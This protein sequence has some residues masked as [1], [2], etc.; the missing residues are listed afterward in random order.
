MFSERETRI[1]LVPN[2]VFRQSLQMV[3]EGDDEIKKIRIPVFSIFTETRE[4]FLSCI[5]GFVKLLN[6]TRNLKFQVIPKHQK[7]TFFCT[8]SD[9]EVQQIRAYLFYKKR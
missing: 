4:N 6:F 2:T 5:P 8:I 3:V 9:N 7:F 1:L